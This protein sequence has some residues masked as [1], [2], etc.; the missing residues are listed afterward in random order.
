MKSL[1]IFIVDDNKD[2]AQGMAMLLELEGHNV[3][4]AYSGE[5]ALDIFKQQDFDITFMDIKMPGM[6]G[7]ESFFEIRKIKSNAKVIMMTAYSVKELLQQA[8]DGGAMGVLDKPV[9]PDKIQKILES[10]KPAGIILVADDDADFVESLEMSLS[11]SGYSVLVSGDGQQA[12]D[13]VLQNDIDVLVLDLRLP[14]LS[15]LEVY[16]KLKQQHHCLPTLI[17]TGYAIEEA[18]TI[19]SLKTLSVAGCLIKPFPPEAILEAI[20]NIMV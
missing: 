11:Q 17:I 3:T 4:L 19:S 8:I 20:E 1:N 10:V 12:I 15:G 16:M 13:L 18:E 5:Q 7:V 14:V 6:N 2:L 9:D